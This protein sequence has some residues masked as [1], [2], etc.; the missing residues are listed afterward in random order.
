[1]KLLASQLK[2]S[3]FDA[4]KILLNAQL[5][6]T[7][8]YGPIFRTKF[9]GLRPVGNVK[10][11]NAADVAT[12]LRSEGHTPVRPDSPV[13]EYYREK[14]KKP[15]GL[16][17]GNGPD[18]YKHRRLVSKRML[19]PKSVAQYEPDFNE[20]VTQFVLR[21]DNLRGSHGL[22]NEVPQLE[23]ELF[24]WS[25]ESVSLLLFD[26]RFGSLDDK[27]N[28]EVQEYINHIG[29]FLVTSSFIDVLPV[30]MHEVFP[31]KMYKQFAESYDKLY[32]FT[33]MTIERK[34]KEF[35]EQ[36][37]LHYCRIRRES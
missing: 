36:G 13:R 23:N 33:E 18:W 22:E 1:M 16:F 7:R 20:I 35:Q 4:G 9:T 2:T 37:K 19:R 17:F 31:T 12:V 30:W 26:E 8:K 11:A 24:K 10:V 6:D 25:F 21:L 34:F 27:M 14:T 28:P 29:K 32:R 3:D 5:R 15:A